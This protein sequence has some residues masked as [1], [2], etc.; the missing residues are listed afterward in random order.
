M[1]GVRPT[2]D[3]DKKYSHNPVL[4]VAEEI[5]AALNG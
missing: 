3:K 4:Q 5:I 2:E 1:T